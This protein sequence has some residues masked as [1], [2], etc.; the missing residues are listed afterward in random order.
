MAG[1]EPAFAV[2]ETLVF[3]LFAACV[4]EARRDR[5]QLVAL[6]ALAVYGLTLEAATI[7]AFE[8]HRYGTFLV[9]LGPVPVGIGLGWASIVHSAWRIAAR[10]RGVLPRAALAA[11]LG[12]GIDLTMD[13][14]AI[15]LGYWTWS[16]PGPWFGIPLVNFAGWIAV[17]FLAVA[18]TGILER[19]LG[20]WAVPAAV[21]AS[22]LCLLP[23]ILAWLLVVP[24]WLEGVLLAGAVCVLAVL[25]HRGL[26]VEGRKTPPVPF[27]VQAGFHLFFLAAAVVLALAGAAPPLLAGIGLAL[28]AAVAFL[29]LEGRGTGRPQR[30]AR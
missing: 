6:A 21:L 29:R 5:R 8:Y 11:L 26:P 3:G 1:V 27:V 30:D 16:V 22:L 20:P 28:A 13:A 4:W 14:V 18:W 23:F 24:P 9:M 2:F 10:L 25:A 17:V 15:R 7:A 19:R 12:L